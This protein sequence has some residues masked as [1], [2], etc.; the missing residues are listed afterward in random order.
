MHHQSPLFVKKRYLISAAAPNTR[1]MTIS[2]ATR[3]IPPIMPDIMSF[4]I[5][6]SFGRLRDSQFRYDRFRL[7]RRSWF[8]RRRQTEAFDEPEDR[9]DHDERKY[10]RRDHA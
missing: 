3:L 6:T 9:G 2:A 10:G 7:H 4:I 8:A 1:T 5:F